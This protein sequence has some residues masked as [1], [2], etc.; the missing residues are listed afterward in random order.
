MHNR[1]NSRNTRFLKQSVQITGYG[2]DSFEKLT[3]DLAKIC[4][5]FRRA[6]GPQLQDIGSTSQEDGF[7]AIDAS[8]PYFSV[9][10]GRKQGKERS[11]TDDMDPKGYL[12]KA[13]NTM[14]VH[15]EENKVYYH[16]PKLQCSV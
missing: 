6:A 2:N 4:A 15:T 13:A 5:I 9:R 10:S 1:S 14:Y 16:I 7:T 3:T 12:R 8:N 11:I